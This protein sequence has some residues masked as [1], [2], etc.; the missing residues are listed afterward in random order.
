MCIVKRMDREICKGNKWMKTAIHQRRSEMGG[1]EEADSI[2]LR[3][4][5][6]RNRSCE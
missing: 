4:G 2:D 3:R 1:S 5:V 6:E